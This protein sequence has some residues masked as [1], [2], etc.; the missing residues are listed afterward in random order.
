MW[1]DVNLCAYEKKKLV[2]ALE[3]ISSLKV[4]KYNGTAILTDV[5]IRQVKEAMSSSTVIQ[6]FNDG[7]YNKK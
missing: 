5:G 3:Q 1:R 2:S 6:G 7:T 4:A